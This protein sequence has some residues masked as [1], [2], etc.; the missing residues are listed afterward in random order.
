[1]GGVKIGHRAQLVR[2][3]G[4]DDLAGKPTAFVI[5]DPFRIGSDIHG[6]GES[7][8]NVCFQAARPVPS[9]HGFLW[10]GLQSEGLVCCVYEAIWGHGGTTSQG[11]RVVIDTREA[12]AALAY[13]RS[14][15]VRGATPASVTSM[16]EEEA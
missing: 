3:P 13:L 4:I 7:V 14:L 9:V 8:V 11:T 16:G 2:R 5:V 15:I 1:M 6:L 10:Q 12:R